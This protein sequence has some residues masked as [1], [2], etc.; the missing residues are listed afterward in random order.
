MPQS[1]LRPVKMTEPQL[2]DLIDDPIVKLLM[3]R[4]GVKQEVLM[5]LILGILDESEAKHDGRAAGTKNAA[6][7]L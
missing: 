5:P 7:A 2:K 4:D 3:K 6:S 1:S